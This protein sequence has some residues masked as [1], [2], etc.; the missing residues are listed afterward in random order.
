MKVCT[1]FWIIFIFLSFSSA[2]KGD[3]PT[4][5]DIRISNSPAHLNLRFHVAN[6]FSPKIEEAINNG[7]PTTFTYSVM[8]YQ[9]R[10]FWNDKFLAASTL[11]KTIK[12][13]NLKNEY[14]IVTTIKENENSTSSLVLSTLEEAKKNICQVE[15]LSVYPIWKLERNNT[16]YFEIKAAAEGVKPPPYIHYFLF[17]LD[18]KYFETDWAIEIFRY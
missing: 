1:I 5:Q 17:F 6:S 13:D 15:I 18:W 2:S 4:V 14:T 9:Q 16:Y 12:F 3:G 8:L 7:I 11:L 10:S